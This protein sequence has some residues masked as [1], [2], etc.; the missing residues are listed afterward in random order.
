MPTTRSSAR[1]SIRRCSPA[2]GFRATR[3]LYLFVGKASCIDCHNGYLLSD[4]DFH[5]IGVP[6]AG[7]HIPTVQDC[8]TGSARCDCTAG[9]ETS[10]CLPA[11]A[12]SGLKKLIE[13]GVAK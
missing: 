2:T 8:P 7:D 10:S 4:G 3:G 11:G 12:W 13:D 5:N 1:A 9:A 6:Q